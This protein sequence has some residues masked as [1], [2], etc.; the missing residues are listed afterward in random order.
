MSIAGQIAD[1]LTI[2]TQH[3]IIAGH[4]GLGYGYGHYGGYYSGGAKHPG[5][6][7]GDGKPTFLN[8]P[9]LRQNARR[10]YHENLI[11]RSIVDR[12]ADTVADVGLKREFSP[13]AETLRISSETSE[14]WRADAGNR[15]DLWAGSKKCHRSE[16]M[17][18]YQ[19]QRLYA[20]SQQ[21]DN[22]IFVRFYYSNRRDLLNP[23]QFDFID[24]DQIVGDAITTS[25]G[26]FSQR[27]GIIKDSANKELGYKVRV[28]ID[29]KT[30]T[31]TIAAMGRSGRPQMI[32]GFAPEYA[33]QTRGY[34]RL[35]H[36]LQE[37][38]N[39]TDFSS[40]Q[41]HK[42]INQSQVWVSV[43]PG[44]DAAA[45]N[46]FDFGDVPAGPASRQYGSHPTPPEDAKHVTPESLTPVDYYEMPTAFSSQPGSWGVFGLNRGEELKPFVNT[47]PADSFD[48]FVDSFAAYLSAATGVP[49]EIMLMR[50]GENYSASRAALI[51]FWR[52]ARIWQHEMEVDFLNV[53]TEAW[54]SEEIAAGRI[55][56]PGWSDPI[57][58]AAWMRGTWHGAALPNIDPVRLA[59]ADLINVKE[60][61]AKTHDMVAREVSGSDGKSNRA[62]I[63]QELKEMPQTQTVQQAN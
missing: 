1:R 17:N 39:L 40:A 59:K 27:D 14:V 35:S 9:R 19:A 5:G 7:S 38:Q 41:I 45:S 10:A 34:S 56:A 4:Y 31:V 25:M 11:A 50:F 18:L 51:L 58:R 62:K 47:A 55:S 36:A 44:T 57:L 48:K 33:G 6:I 2:L 52:I 49:V 61:G 3:K 29:G 54:L 23:L 43:K 30:E 37:F 28:R 15:F 24:P 12:Y 53:L 63:T 20:A 60:L 42:A 13:D 46:P 26:Y 16:T 32:H 8:H 22:D 21:R